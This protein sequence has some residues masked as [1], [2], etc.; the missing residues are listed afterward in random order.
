MSTLYL[1]GFGKFGDV[2]TNPTSE[3]IA[4]FK[5]DHAPLAPNNCVKECL[6]VLHVSKAGIDDY[7]DSVHVASNNISIHLGINNKASKFVLEQYA[8]NCMNFRIPDE[9]GYQPEMEKIDEIQ[10][11]DVGNE[12]SF[13]V[14]DIVKKLKTEGFNVDVS[15]D[16]GRY[17]CNYVYFKSLQ[18]QIS[19]GRSIK[20][21]I[22]VHVPPFSVIDKDTQSKFVK[23]VVELLCD[24]SA[25][26]GKNPFTFC[27]LFCS[28]K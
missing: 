27:S 3:L 16:P 22:F 12:T 8:Y 15:D 10:D 28:A 1:T 6:D 18:R 13:Y 21:S 23:R 19:L 26:E 20:R 7:F 5:A 24:E 9:A 11:L 4:A 17:C 2:E 14:S 25:V